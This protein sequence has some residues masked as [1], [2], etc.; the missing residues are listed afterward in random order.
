MA[1]ALALFFGSIC[2]CLHCKLQQLQFTMEAIAEA[3]SLN[4]IKVLK[5]FSS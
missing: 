2:Y 5:C 4:P 3:M 1:S